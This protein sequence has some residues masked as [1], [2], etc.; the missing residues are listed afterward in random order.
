MSF[1]VNVA[2]AVDLYD[3]SGGGSKFF[4]TAIGKYGGTTEFSCNMWPSTYSSY[5]IE[6]IKRETA[7]LGES[8]FNYMSTSEVK[9]V[10][11]DMSYVTG[12]VNSCTKF[13]VNQGDRSVSCL[14]GTFGG[15]H[16]LEGMI[17]YNLYDNVG[18]WY[19]K[20]KVK[21]EILGLRLPT[22][23][24]IK[25]FNGKLIENSVKL[26]QDK[27]SV[28]WDN[29][30]ITS[31]DSPDVAF[32]VMIDKVFIGN[33]QEVVS[34]HQGYV[35]KIGIII[36][37]N[38]DKSDFVGESGTASSTTH[39]LDNADRSGWSAVE[40]YATGSD[41]RDADATIKYL[42]FQ[43]GNSDQHGTDIFNTGSNYA[44]TSTHY[45]NVNN[46]TNWLGTLGY[47]GYPGHKTYLRFRRVGNTIR[48]NQSK[49]S[50]MDGYKSDSAE[51]VANVNQFNA[52]DKVCIMLNQYLYTWNAPITQFL[53]LETIPNNFVISYNLA[54]DSPQYASRSL[55][56]ADLK[57][58]S[59]NLN[60]DYG[61]YFNN[62]YD[63]S[64]VPNDFSGATALTNKTFFTVHMKNGTDDVSANFFHKNIAS[65]SYNT[66]KT[67]V[68]GFVN[69]GR[70]CSYDVV[71]SGG[72]VLTG[73]GLTNTTKTI[74]I[75]Q[76][77]DGVAFP[78]SIGQTYTLKQIDIWNGGGTDSTGNG[79]TLTRSV[80]SEVKYVYPFRYVSSEY[81]ALS[82]LNVTPTF[83]S[84]KITINYVNTPNDVPS[85]AFII[86]HIFRYDFYVKIKVTQVL[87]G[88]GHTGR[89]GSIMAGRAIGT[90]DLAHT[91]RNGYSGTTIDG[92]YITYGLGMGSWNSDRN[93]SRDGTFYVMYERKNGTL[94]T[95][96]NGN[97]SS[98]AD[99]NYGWTAG[100]IFRPTHDGG[101]NGTAT[102]SIQSQG[103][104]LIGLANYSDFTTSGSVK[105]FEVIETRDELG[106]GEIWLGFYGNST[107]AGF[108][109]LREIS[110]THTSGSI[111]N[112]NLGL[113]TN[114]TS[115][116]HRS[117]TGDLR[118]YTDVNGNQNSIPT[119][120][121]GGTAWGHGGGFM[122][123]D[124]PSAGSHMFMTFKLN[125]TPTI[126]GGTAWKG[127]LNGSPAP[128]NFTSISLY[129]TKVN[130]STMT[131]INNVG[132]GSQW[133]SLGIN[134]T[135]TNV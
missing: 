115:G 60:G 13:Y 34:L 48:I 12:T 114:P 102:P 107:S 93:N 23:F 46:N 37:Q 135:L 100:S 32:S 9:D 129:T 29:T 22:I 106:A 133:S 73:S 1:A 68:A 10:S 49:T 105:T 69:G 88:S 111:S 28:E 90:A 38:I 125:A 26:S 75:R 5:K 134:L 6:T 77:S 47:F 67:G 103:D 120:F 132:V 94:R 126:T 66:I 98:T 64:F 35:C 121:S 72:A 74:R 8:S 119:L 89:M 117:T 53:K 61:K 42:Y 130:P 127:D 14:P 59:F 41:P 33:F 50:L 87:N 25:T 99:T 118:Y 65:S 123:F 62:T 30:G 104:V 108:S 15:S 54:S 84:K 63:V 78:G 51:Y 3:L 4:I 19:S 85:Y 24:A 11:F 97:G 16:E 39:N 31:S 109:N 82:F 110:I 56:I 44:S 112:G 80:K 20:V 128:G 122:T 17:F 96:A 95:W 57:D 52:G 81:P 92:N 86:N 116:F 131:D 91:V 21:K 43:A 101:T 83:N 36:G 58:I 70:D 71:D 45:Q 7:E 55:T 124:I 76:T 40:Q 2:K 113:I 79:V 18:G 27:M